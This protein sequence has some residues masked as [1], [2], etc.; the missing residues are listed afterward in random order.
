MSINVEEELRKNLKNQLKL[1]EKINLIL[2]CMMHLY[3]I[4]LYKS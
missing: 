2:V 3:Q 1:Q 4:L